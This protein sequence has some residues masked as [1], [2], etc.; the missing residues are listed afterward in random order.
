MRAAASLLALYDHDLKC[1]EGR[2]SKIFLSRL[3]EL[4]PIAKG[5]KINEVTFGF[6]DVTFNFLRPKIADTGTVVTLGKFSISSGK[7]ISLL[8]ETIEGRIIKKKILYRLFK[9]QLKQV[10]L[11][12]DDVTCDV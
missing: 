9:L 12:N 6:H 1:I 3:F 5:F 10:C 2:I 7:E 4:N 11:K 8:L